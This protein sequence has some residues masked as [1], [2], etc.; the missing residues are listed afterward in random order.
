MFAQNGV[1]PKKEEETMNN[2]TNR[3]SNIPRTFGMALLGMSLRR[4]S[5]TKTA[6][7]LMSVRRNQ[8]NMLVAFTALLVGQASAQVSRVNGFTVLTVP[9]S[10]S[11]LASANY[12]NAKSMALPVNTAYPMTR[13]GPD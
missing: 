7:R 5:M 4:K 13:S 9:N 10:A 2:N 11:Q 6:I 1:T 12:A 8:F 3:T